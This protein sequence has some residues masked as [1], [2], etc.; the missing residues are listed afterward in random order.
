MIKILAIAVAGLVLSG[1]ASLGTFLNADQSDKSVGARVL[2]DIQGCTRS[3]RG[4]LGAGV[5]GS[6]EI[7]CDP[8]VKDG[9]HTEPAKAKAGPN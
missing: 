3:Y 1:C 7:N 8:I 4:A 6:F 2:N 9:T 5:S